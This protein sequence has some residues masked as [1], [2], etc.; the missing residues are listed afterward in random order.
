MLPVVRGERETRWQI[1]LYTLIL[2]AFTLTLPL[3]GLGSWLYWWGAM[4]LGLWLIR[5]AGKVWRGTGNKV[6]W[7][8]YR[9]S[10]MYLAFLFLVLM[11]DA[12]V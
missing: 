4:G 8:M 1:F 3:F 5:A 6:A 11:I 10:S 7:K 9:H 12:V 2:V